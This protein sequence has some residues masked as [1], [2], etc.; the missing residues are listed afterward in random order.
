[1][2]AVSDEPRTPGGGRRRPAAGAPASGRLRSLRL[3]VWNRWNGGE[4]FVAPPRSEWSPALRRAR[5]IGLAL[6]GVGFL[7]FCA[8]SLIQVK[9]FALTA[10]FSWYQQ[11][12]YLFGH[13]HLSPQVTAGGIAIHGYGVAQGHP[14]PFWV[15]AG[16]FFVVPLGLIYRLFPHPETLKWMQDLALCGTQVIAFMWI[17]D[18]VAARKR[19][20]SPRTGVWLIVLGF[21]LLVANPWFIW[22]ASF[23]I[24]SETFAT[25]FVVGAARDLHRGRRTAWAW[26]IGAILCSAVGATYLIA[27]SVGAV[28]T[29]RRSLRLGLGLALLGIIWLGILGLLGLLSVVQTYLYQS[30]ITG[31][32][33]ATTGQH[34]VRG[35]WYGIARPGSESVTYPALVKAAVERPW[36]VLS[37][38]WANHAN[39]WGSV[40]AAGLLGLV[41]IPVLIPSLIV[42]VQGGF[43]QGAS[44]PGFQNI[45]VG[46]LMAVGTVALC[47]MLA[48]RL[49]EGRRWL[50]RIVL[51]LLAL[52]TI[53][54]GAIW[55][56]KLGDQWLNVSPQA[57][58]ALRTV[59]AKIGP[60]DE[61]VA[62]QGVSGAFAARQWAYSIVYPRTPIQVH[63]PRKVWFIFAPFDGTETIP[64]SNTLAMVKILSHYHGMHLVVDS[65]DVWAFEWVPPPGLREFVLAAPEPSAP[66]VSTLTGSSGRA[67]ISKTPS[68]SHATSNGQPGYVIDRDFWRVLKGRYRVS[69]R[70][71]ASALTNVEVWD[72]TTNTLLRRVVLTHTHGIK[73]VNLTVTL[74]RTGAQPAIG[75]TA[76]WSITSLETPGDNLELRVWTAGAAGSVNVYS[77][78]ITTLH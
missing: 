29:R 61:V 70:V 9:R 5:V 34:Y 15:N 71:S 28:I 7:G 56:P 13:G 78:A 30:V 41:W 43:Y 50:L 31:G 21:V 53:V 45:L 73:R 52:N 72:D 2:S 67:V 23:D 40:S 55:F 14:V 59:Q 25:L 57:A 36:A 1:M 8:W 63:A 12:A 64:S 42:L 27:V 46:G 44:L 24:H 62:S 6:I 37:A 10:D 4:P 11:A 77:A 54:W 17:C 33:A 58:A 60:N 51:V 39:L 18:L 49:G 69:T 74:N 48:S 19:E 68:E 26:G 38:L 20:G 16:E 75:G 22:S 32:A 66:A 76:L 47:A 65:G 35:V 3:S